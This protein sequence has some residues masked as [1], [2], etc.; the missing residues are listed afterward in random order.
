M[1]HD[2]PAAWPACQSMAPRVPVN[3]CAMVWCASATC[4]CCPDADS[5]KRPG[6]QDVYCAAGRLASAPSGERQSEPLTLRRDSSVGLA[7]AGSFTGGPSE[8]QGQLFSASTA[9]L[10][11]DY[12]DTLGQPP[13]SCMLLCNMPSPS[14]LPCCLA[15]EMQARRGLAW[16]LHLQI[17]CINGSSAL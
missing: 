5:V 8:Q 4:K 12:F 11:L 9:D 14:Q 13:G 2:E 10:D 6:S 16:T 15:A 1:Y 3:T 7:S 17:A